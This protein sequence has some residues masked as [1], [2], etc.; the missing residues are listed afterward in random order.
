MAV[1]PRQGLLQALAGEIRG[2]IKTTVTDTDE[3]QVGGQ[4][5]S[6]SGE[7]GDDS[8]VLQPRPV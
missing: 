3:K 7:D 5:R 6:E 8:R 4:L 2:C 1:L